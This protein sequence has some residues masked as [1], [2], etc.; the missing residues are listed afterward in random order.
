VYREKPAN[1]AAAHAVTLARPWASKNAQRSGRCVRER[2]T[3]LFEGSGPRAG[4]G[5]A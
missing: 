1:V 3:P 4:L 5:V 2:R